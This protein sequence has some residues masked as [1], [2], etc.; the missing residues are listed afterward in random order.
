MLSR[1][2]PD[3]YTQFSL[4]KANDEDLMFSFRVKKRTNIGIHGI[5]DAVSLYF[6]PIC[7]GSIKKAQK[8]LD[9]KTYTRLAQND[10]DDSEE[11]FAYG[12]FKS[13]R[14]KNKLIN[15]Q[16]DYNRLR[17]LLMKA[18]V[19]WFGTQ[20]LIIPNMAT[21]ADLENE[22]VKLYGV[23]KYFAFGT[24][25][26]KVAQHV[27][28]YAT[29]TLDRES[30]G[31]SSIHT[32]D[33]DII[34]FPTEVRNNM[35]LYTFFIKSPESTFYP[36]LP[37]PDWIF[38]VERGHVNMKYDSLRRFII[39]AADDEKDFPEIKQAIIE[40][41]ISV[42]PDSLVTCEKTSKE[43]IIARLTILVTH[44]CICTKAL[45]HVFDDGSEISRWRR[46]KK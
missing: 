26:E 18:R 34:V 21:L 38:V 43:L 3:F 14:T 10:D 42:C 6:E 19:A 24:L 23:R 15:H 37:V 20:G 27:I 5:L 39:V 17:D 9:L 30:F 1:N 45:R 12:K 16:I 7:Y 36:N 35:I 8:T 2:D 25:E 31:K 29:T 46:I 22:D 44:F 28:K 40:A 41:A 32:P 33:N 11:Y 4:E 13:C